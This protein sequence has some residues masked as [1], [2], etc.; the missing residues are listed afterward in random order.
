[1]VKLLIVKDLTHIGQQSHWASITIATDATTVLVLVRSL[2]IHYIMV[3]LLTVCAIKGLTHLVTVVSV[4][5][6]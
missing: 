3:K 2:P 5:I 4:L 6:N 1:M